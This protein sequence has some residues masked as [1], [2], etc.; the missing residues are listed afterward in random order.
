MEDP[1]SYF[2][3]MIIVLFGL[4][5]PTADV[6]TDFLLAITIIVGKEVWK[7]TRAQW[8]GAHGPELIRE[9][10]RFCGLLDGSRYVFGATTLVF[11]TLSFL[12]KSLFDRET[13]VYAKI[14][15]ICS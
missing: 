11:P 1:M 9:D 10:F 14:R 8:A 2:E 3:A 7:E 15:Q 6:G 13:F 5:L 4:I 12:F